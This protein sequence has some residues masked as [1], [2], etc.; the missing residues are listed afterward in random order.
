[1]KW[2]PWFVTEVFKPLKCIEVQKPGYYILGLF[3]QLKLPPSAGRFGPNKK[4]QYPSTVESLRKTLVFHG[5]SLDKS[6]SYKLS[7][8]R[9]PE[10]LHLN[11]C[12]VDHDQQP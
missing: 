11:V 1:M 5:C 4:S 10:V 6:K 12:V 2:E 7:S 3:S 9:F 8:Q